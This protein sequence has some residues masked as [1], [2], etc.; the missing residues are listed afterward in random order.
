MTQFSDYYGFFLVRLSSETH[1]PTEMAIAG[2]WSRMT[3][4][5]NTAATQ[6]Q[7][8]I[9]FSTKAHPCMKERVRAVIGKYWSGEIKHVR[10]APSLITQ[11]FTE[12]KRL[13]FS[14]MVCFIPLFLQSGWLH[15]S[16]G[17]S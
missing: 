8:D 11:L 5:P 3:P 15:R 10:K 16:I 17:A 7:K 12:L 2:N 13:H 6:F 9:V 4:H 14:Q 1:R